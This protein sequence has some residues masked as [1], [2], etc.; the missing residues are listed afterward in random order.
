M[1]ETSTKKKLHP[2][3][4]VGIGCGVLLVLVMGVVAVGGLFLARKAKDVIEE[5][6]ENPAAVAA[7]T[8]VRLNPE[9]ETIDSDRDAGTITVR[10]KSTGKV[11]IFNYEDIQEGRFSFEGEDGEVLSIDASDASD[12]SE[13]LVQMTSSDGQKTT[14]GAT[15]D[16]VELPSWLP[17][18]PGPVTD[19]AGFSS[20]T[21]ER[22]SG[23]FTFKVE[24]AGAEVLTFYEEVMEDLNLEASRNAHEGGGGS[25]TTISGRS[26]E[27][28]LNVT[29]AESGKEAA[30]VIAYEGPD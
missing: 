22:R 7:E 10:E 12:G 4:W 9:L 17:H 24:G 15:G 6:R 20:V 2:L 30:V 8:F 5:V 21:N 14:F 19:H 27:H 26:E 1:E 11:T 13:A 16:A 18:F 28:T 29:V 3:A 23:T 25:F